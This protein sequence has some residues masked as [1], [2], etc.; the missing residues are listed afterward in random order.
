MQ[1]Y[2]KKIEVGNPLINLEMWELYQEYQTLKTDEQLVNFYHKL[3][4]IVEVFYMCNRK[5]KVFENFIYSMIAY[6]TGV[7][8]NPVFFLMQQTLRDHEA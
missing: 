5:N 3:L 8:V 7:D 4:D 2:L 6:S 1:N